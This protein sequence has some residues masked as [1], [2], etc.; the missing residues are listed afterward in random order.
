MKTFAAL[1][2]NFHQCSHRDGFAMIAKTI[3]VTALICTSH[4]NGQGAVS[5]PIPPS[6]HSLKMGPLARADFF[7]IGV[8]LQSPYNAPKFSAAGI[9]LYVGLYKGPTETQLADLKRFHMP[10]LCTQNDVGLKH[11]DDPTIMGWMQHDEPDNA[12]LLAS[13][14]GYGPPIAPSTVISNYRLLHQRDPSRPVFLNLGAGVIWDAWHGR[15]VRTNHPEDYAQ[16]IQGGDIVSF[17]IYPGCSS[18]PAIAGKIWM[19][20]DGVA[21]L[22]KL[23]NGQRTIWN[24]IECTHI[25]NPNAV[26]T[27]AQV[28]A[29]VW[30]SLVRG[31][32]GI[33]YFVH[34]FKPK[35]IE[36][37]L[38]VDPAMLRMVT[39][40]NVQINSL[41]SILNSPTV[42]NGVAL[43]ST[44]SAVPVEAI[45][46]RHG[47]IT[48][49]FSVPFRP[50]A[51]NVRFQVPGL[52]GQTKAQVLGE[53]RTVDVTDG[54]F[55]DKFASWDVHLYCIPD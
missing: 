6:N 4:A 22:N 11:I 9:N 53:A 24:F 36:A 15:G 50:G 8:W 7:P 37:E 45:V 23:S 54:V 55:L 19:V 34:Q 31:S 28:R 52:K 47:A 29:E 40:T 38:L 46:K 48:Y 32:R 27:P 42:L 30:M 44:N 14:H 33:V 1:R 10:V 12:Q 41:A 43:R 2:M 25:E 13:G 35:F 51:T 3:I 16:Y 17:D 39:M 5:V 20:A 49:V 18:D 26:A 21:R